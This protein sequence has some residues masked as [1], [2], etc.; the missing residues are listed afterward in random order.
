MG[1][2]SSLPRDWPQGSLCNENGARSSDRGWEAAVKK[3]LFA[4]IH[5]LIPA[6]HCSLGNSPSL[7]T[8]GE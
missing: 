4:K 1:E 8:P 5:T 3:K 2:Q 6:C 7:L